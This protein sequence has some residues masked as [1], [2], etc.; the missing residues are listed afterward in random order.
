M[1]INEMG[2]LKN[3]KVELNK[4]ECQRGDQDFGYF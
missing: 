1:G 4:I 3:S 2:L